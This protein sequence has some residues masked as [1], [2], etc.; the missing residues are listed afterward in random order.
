VVPLVL[1][2]LVLLMK[3]AVAEKRGHI[4]GE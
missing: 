2:A 1:V 4:G 3:R